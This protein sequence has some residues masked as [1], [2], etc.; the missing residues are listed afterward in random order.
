[1][2]DE[3]DG[4]SVAGVESH[5]RTVLRLLPAWYRK[6]RE[7]EMVATFLED[8]AELD[9]LEA[10]YRWPRWSEMAGVVGAAIRLR[11]GGADAPPRS[12]AWGET[13]RLV[14]L[15]GLLAYS[16]LTVLGCAAVAGLPVHDLKLSTA[17]PWAVP[18]VG[19]VG[20]FM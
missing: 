13:G 17:L 2:S 8:N 9:D 15:L 11:L 19:A 16:T 1:M 12:I 18:T 3:E 7:E 4:I 14:A 5:Y 6:E 10:E 20:S